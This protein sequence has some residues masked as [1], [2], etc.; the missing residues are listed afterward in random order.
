VLV[1]VEVEVEAQKDQPATSQVL[2]LGLNR[3]SPLNLISISI[4]AKK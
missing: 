1:L 3:K 2:V 4:L